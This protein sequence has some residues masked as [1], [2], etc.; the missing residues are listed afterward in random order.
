MDKVTLNRI[1]SLPFEGELSLKIPEKSVN[2]LLRDCL[3]IS[4]IDDLS[5][6]LHEGY[7]TFKGDV[8]MVITSIPVS[9]DLEIQDIIFDGSK[10]IIELRDHS[11]TLISITKLL[12]F[13]GS[14]FS[15]M[16]SVGGK[17]I[18]IDL[19]SK[20]EKF[21]E[22][23]TPQMKNII[24]RLKIMKP[25]FFESNMKLKIKKEAIE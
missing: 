8:S 19:S 3:N 1:L 11:N 21:Y 5:I 15:K 20:F 22:K 12:S 24:K 9:L 2:S 13:I 18:R 16:V 17:D 23:Q 10:F 4:F 7:F 25:E 14:M 6:S